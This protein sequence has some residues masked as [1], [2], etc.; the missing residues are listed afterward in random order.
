MKLSI[1]KPKGISG[2]PETDPGLKFLTDLK[3]ARDKTSKFKEKNQKVLEQLYELQQDETNILEAL[4][5]HYKALAE[6]LDSAGTKTLV[7]HAGL[8]LVV[9]A[10][11]KFDADKLVKLK[12]KLLEL[13]VFKYTIT[14]NEVDRLVAAGVIDQKTLQTVISYTPA[15]SVEADVE[16]I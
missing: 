14:V 5:K 12:P 1:T 11:R 15:M 9:K 4:K 10:S 6:R 8:R 13:N 2:K 3:A 16:V 7:K